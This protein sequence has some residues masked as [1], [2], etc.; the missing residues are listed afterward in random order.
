MLV[1]ALVLFASPWLFEYRAD[2]RPDWNAWVIA[3]IVA[4]VALASLAEFSEWEDW[5][6]LVL[7]GWLIVAPWLMGFGHDS[8]AALAQRVIGILLI[9]ISAWAAFNDHRRLGSG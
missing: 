7:G 9:A 5:V 4:Y 3:I 6:I 8:P 2:V 1:L